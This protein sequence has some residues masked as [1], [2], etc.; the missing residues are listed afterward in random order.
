MAEACGGSS[1]HKPSKLYRTDSPQEMTT[2]QRTNSVMEQEQQPHRFSD[3]ER[4]LLGKLHTAWMRLQHIDNEKVGSELSKSRQSQYDGKSV[5]RSFDDTLL[6]RD[7]EY[8]TPSRKSRHRNSA[9]RVAP[10][11]SYRSTSFDCWVRDGETSFDIDLDND[12]EEQSKS[13]AESKDTLES[14]FEFQ[15]FLSKMETAKYALSEDCFDAVDVRRLPFTAWQIVAVCI[16]EGWAPIDSCSAVLQSYV[17]GDPLVRFDDWSWCA[18]LRSM[19]DLGVLLLPDLSLHLHRHMSSPSELFLKNLD[20]FLVDV[21]GPF[22]VRHIVGR[23]LCN[24]SLQALVWNW[25]GVLSWKQQELLDSSTETAFHMTLR[26]SQEHTVGYATRFLLNSMSDRTVTSSRSPK[27]TPQNRID[28]QVGENVTEAQFMNVFLTLPKVYL[29]IRKAMWDSDKKRFLYSINDVNRT[30]IQRRLNQMDKQDGISYSTKHNDTAAY[31]ETLLR[32]HYFLRRCTGR[33]KTETDQLLHFGAYDWVGFDMDH[34][35]IDYKTDATSAVI[36][37]ASL[38]HLVQTTS[39]DCR[40]GR[41]K[42]ASL[43]TVLNYLVQEYPGLESLAAPPHGESPSTFDTPPSIFQFTGRQYPPCWLELAKP[44]YIVDA[45]EGNIIVVDACYYVRRVFHG[46]RITNGEEAMRQ[47]VHHTHKQPK[48]ADCFLC[49]LDSLKQRCC[50]RPSPD[51]ATG[52]YAPILSYF[53]APV[54]PLYALLVSACDDFVRLQNGTFQS[55]V[56][57]QLWVAAQKSTRF[58]YSRFSVNGWSSILQNPSKFLRLEKCRHTKRWIRGLRRGG[59]GVKAS[60]CFLLTNSDWKQT[61]TLMSFAFG[62]DWLSLF[63]LVIVN[64]KKSKFRRS[65]AAH[66]ND[67]GNQLGRVKQDSEKGSNVSSH[68]AEKQKGFSLLNPETGKVQALDDSWLQHESKQ[69]QLVE[70]L[71]TRWGALP[72][73]LQA[74][75]SGVGSAF[76]TTAVLSGGGIRQFLA[77]I[78]H[79]TRS[80][81]PTGTRMEAKF[82]VLYIGDHVYNDIVAPEIEGVTWHTVAISPEMSLTTLPCKALE[83]IDPSD[84]F[85]HQWVPVRTSFGKLKSE[86][87]HDILPVSI[88]GAFTA[89]NWES[90]Q[91]PTD[92]SCSEFWLDRL[93][94]DSSVLRVPSVCWLM[95]ILRTRKSYSSIALLVGRSLLSTNT[96]GVY[97]SQ[98]R[99]CIDEGD[100]VATVIRLQRLDEAESVQKENFFSRLLEYL[101][102]S[103]SK[104]LLNPF[105]TLNR[106][107]DGTSKA[108]K[109]KHSLALIPGRSTSVSYNSVATLKMVA[110]AEAK[111]QEFS[112]EI[113]NASPVRQ[114]N[115]EYSKVI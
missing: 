6:V 85:S 100:L 61:N 45:L 67:D 37:E 17:S 2:R 99:A 90:R 64:A 27:I 28:E 51:S 69:Q 32:V 30:R 7:A 39:R 73:N 15:E 101:G 86:H 33:R 54:L 80:E 104:K 12:T 20:T 106:D 29:P 75:G 56:F 66:T 36:W 71:A 41:E 113:E 95:E 87:P 52:R 96:H 3:E 72:V 5:P 78:E 79:V 82:S 89:S 68:S 98:F 23:A 59:S 8:S 50:D 14:S 9:K 108:S 97:S 60:R 16:L 46:G 10:G 26:L 93:S 53:D 103:S 110:H 84:A 74:L 21:V 31:L 77:T 102:S 24:Q 92:I 44:G 57:T 94:L 38:T 42:H 58:S 83:K 111:K 48:E 91:T 18:M 47:Y 88:N 43:N 112:N 107:N 105:F 114:S 49:F 22:V 13:R 62:A 25:M 115:R 65:L 11:D 70:E 4:E 76:G 109:M 63:D 19:D 40:A 35:L 1:S 81:L 34:T 55:G